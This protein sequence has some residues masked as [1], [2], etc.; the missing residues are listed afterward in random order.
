M[1][2]H[3]RSIGSPSGAC[4]CVD[5]TRRCSHPPPPPSPPFLFCLPSL[6]SAAHPTRP[7][8]PLLDLSLAI[9]PSP[10]QKGTGWTGTAKGGAGQVRGARGHC[11]PP[12]LRFFFFLLLPLL[13]FLLVFWSVPSPFLLR[14]FFLSFLH[15]SSARIL[16]PKHSY[17][18]HGGVGYICALLTNDTWRQFACSPLLLIYKVF[19]NS[20]GLSCLMVLLFLRVLKY[21]VTIIFTT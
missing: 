20:V 8:T 19:L 16:E 4:V 12:N 14:L 5:L 15:S 11:S 17:Q 3:D 21:L 18:D 10:K 2:R 7:P 9:Y 1:S 13:P 6:A